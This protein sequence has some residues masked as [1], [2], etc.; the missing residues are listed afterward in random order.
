M[1]EDD[2]IGRGMTPAEAAAAARR[3][4]GNEN[5]I[6]E[7]YRDASGFTILNHTAR[8]VRIGART[9]IKSPV[10]TVFAT[11]ILSIGIGA[12]VIVFAYA[13]A[14]FFK[15]MH[16]P[17]PGR[18]VKVY[19]SDIGAETLG[20]LTFERYSQYQDR[21]QAFS[22]LG[23]TSAA[24][25]REPIRIGGPGNR[26]VDMTQ[27]ILVN[28]ALFRAVGAGIARG[29]SLEP[30][31]EKAGSPAVVII[32]DEAARQYFAGQ[33][34]PIGQVLFVN[35]TA[36]VVV[37]VVSDA[38]EDVLTILPNPRSPRIY[39]PLVAPVYDNQHV[40]VIGRL[41]RTASR[42]QGQAD[43]ERVAA[44]MSFELKRP[45]AVSVERADLP[46][47]NLLVGLASL[48]AL[49]V[50]IVL[51]VLLIACD[52]IA[53][54]LVARVAARRRE[55][56]IRMALGAGR[57]QLIVQLVAENCLL[58]I[59]GGIGAMIFTLLAART[60]DHAGLSL[61]EASRIT[62]DWRVLFF[63]TIVSLAT[64]LFFGL[65]P[66]LECVNRSVA[67]SLAPGAAEQRADRVRSN[68]LITQIT[69]CTA[70]MITTATI[71]RSSATISFNN[72]GFQSDHVLLSHV[73][74]I[75]TN[76]DRQKKVQ[77]YRTLMDRLANTP[78]I[79]AAT[80]VNS[81]PVQL[82]GGDYFRYGG[83]MALEIARARP[84]NADLPIFVNV[85]SP[86]QFATL[87]IPLIGGRDFRP[88]DDRS[89]MT[90]GIVSRS[91]AAQLWAN[92]N[93]IGQTLQ[94][95]DSTKLTV[96]GV[97]GDVQYNVNFDHTALTPILYLPLNQ[98]IGPNV[99]DTIMIRTS[100]P[101]MKVSGLLYQKVSDIDP[102]LL[103]YDA[104]PLEEQLDR[105]LL[106]FRF[107]E[108][109]T[110]LPGIFAMMLGL[111]GTYGTMAILVTQR[112]REIGIRVA[113]GAEPSSATRL[114]LKEGLR[115]TAAGLAL[116]LGGAFLIALYLSRNI[117]GPH[118]FDPVAFSG[119]SFVIAITAALASYIPARRATRVDPMIVLREE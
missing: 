9:L 51:S 56:G 97:C 36:R 71:V 12:N 16:V 24:G 111:I 68:L 46:P 86:G 39:L 22:E 17:E 100:T 119:M 84:G 19:G 4:L 103:A 20:L 72:R 91:L 52:D 8:D 44:Q 98:Y 108:Y 57:G 66:A 47:S 59:L 18:L 70:L 85:V 58:A 79:D 69:I 114:I 10:F 101:P 7:S 93:P 81:L 15:S 2:L 27:P 87:R 42:S 6:R 117:S 82:P 75:G 90:V 118:F 14:L 88:Q 95:S 113:L 41:K 23:V 26:P 61:P 43:L 76:Y 65:R 67:V 89:A 50:V 109:V 37:G 13:N 102:N 25:V 49:F 33:S 30:S 31:D 77:F 62:F 21:A 54:M 64:T 48:V 3:A 105:A 78:G 34:N 63:A 29:R 110:G 94:L 107:V 55:M 38:F 104:R 99:P 96:I 115:A 28:S 53:I 60:L 45:I 112:R 35:K 92:E 116:G 83:T 1:I 32:N 11:V 74:F 5:V 80:V 40:T 73:N 106:P